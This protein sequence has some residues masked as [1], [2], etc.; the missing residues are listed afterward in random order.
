MGMRE[1][2]GNVTDHKRPDTGKP[3][4]PAS[5]VG[6]YHRT[7]GELEW[8]RKFIL[9]NFLKSPLKTSTSKPVFICTKIPFIVLSCSSRHL[10]F[11]Y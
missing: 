1:D 9:E 2:S 5:P 6:Y 11:T 10:I 3:P 4:C 8:G 7:R